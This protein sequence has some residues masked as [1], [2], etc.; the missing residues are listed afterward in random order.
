MSN[1]QIGSSSEGRKVVKQADW[2]FISRADKQ[3]K[4]YIDSSSEGRQEG[5]QTLF[6]PAQ[7]VFQ[8]CFNKMS[9]R[10]TVQSTPSTESLRC[11]KRRSEKAF[12]SMLEK[13]R[14]KF[15]SKKGIDI[16]VCVHRPFNNLR[17]RFRNKKVIWKLRDYT[18]IVHLE[19][20]NK[21][22]LQYE[23]PSSSFFILFAVIKNCK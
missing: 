2:Q 18:V 22:L 9:V 16:Y 12:L 15:S 11:P 3:S 20:K 8:F 13:K 6:L 5:W 17:L 7:P 23:V 1:R 14:G 4:S 19:F 21:K 10:H